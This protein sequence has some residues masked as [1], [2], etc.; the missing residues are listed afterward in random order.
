MIAYPYV[1]DHT[2]ARHMLYAK[3]GFGRGGVTL[4]ARGQD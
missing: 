4:A 1:L 3:N 2:G